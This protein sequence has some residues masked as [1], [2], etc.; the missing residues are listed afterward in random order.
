MVNG[1]FGI[2]IVV[3]LSN[4][5]NPG[6][7]SGDPIGIQTTNLPLPSGKLYNIAMEY[8]HFE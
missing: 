5:P 3:P 2:R 7:I 6:F 8:P 1:W 4:N